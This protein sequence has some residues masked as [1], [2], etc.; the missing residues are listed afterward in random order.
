[1]K[2]KEELLPLPNPAQVNIKHNN[3]GK[4]RNV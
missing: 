1:V 3:Y 2:P 4:K